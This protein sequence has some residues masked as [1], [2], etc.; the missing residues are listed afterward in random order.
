MA[1]LHWELL[2]ITAQIETL[3][4]SEALPEQRGG[5]LDVDN[6]TI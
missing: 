1:L 4:A 6:C 3:K 2:P 5:T